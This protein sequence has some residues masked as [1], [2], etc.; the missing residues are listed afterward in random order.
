MTT[1]FNKKHPCHLAISISKLSQLPR[2]QS[3]AAMPPSSSRCWGV[4]KRTPLRWQI[5]GR[6]L[7]S[8][9]R[10]MQWYLRWICRYFIGWVSN[11]QKWF[12]TESLK[13]SRQTHNLWERMA[14]AL[15]QIE[16]KHISAPYNCC[17]RLA[18]QKSRIKNVKQIMSLTHHQTSGVRGGLENHYDISQYL[19][20]QTIPFADAKCCNLPFMVR[21]ILCMHSI[22]HAV[23]HDVVSLTNLQRP[24]EEN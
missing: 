2:T 23:R 17:F 16:G 3:I 13:E 20:K 22:A 15:I 9:E 7:P 1:Q 12:C 21:P 18:Y 5:N 6:R 19:I 14:W 24:Y 8:E 11:P 4:R 10:E